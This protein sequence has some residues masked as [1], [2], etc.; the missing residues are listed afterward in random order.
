MTQN[1]PNE[2]QK[3]NET[4]M[5]SDR[6]LVK[7]TEQTLYDVKSRDVVCSRTN[8]GDPLVQDTSLQN[9][10]PS[11]IHNGL[12]SLNNKTD[13]RLVLVPLSMLSLN[14]SSMSCFNS[15]EDLT[16]CYS[17][18]GN[19]KPLE[20]ANKQAVSMITNFPANNLKNQDIGKID[21]HSTLDDNFSSDKLLEQEFGK[22]DSTVHQLHYFDSPPLLSENLLNAKRSRN[23]RSLNLAFQSNHGKTKRR[24]HVSGQ[25]PIS[26]SNICQ[27]CGE[28]AGR[29]NYYGG[30]SCQSCRAFFRRTVEIFAKYVTV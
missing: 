15:K 7:D 24:R 25:D 8:Q 14:G 11:S 6:I 10:N 28:M 13:D 3:R 23:T 5:M 29:H 20:S 21:A 27:V 4:I 22:N 2:I 17:N 26:E 30:R 18:E 12:L 9:S 19:E 16:P 1:E